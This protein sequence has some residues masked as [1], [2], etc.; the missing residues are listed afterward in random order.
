MYYY[1]KY[2]TPFACSVVRQIQSHWIIFTQLN[3]VAVRSCYWGKFLK[4]PTVISVVFFI[5]YDYVWFATLFRVFAMLMRYPA[6]QVVQY[7]VRYQRLGLI[8]PK[9]N[10]FSVIKR[11]ELKCCISF[12]KLCDLQRRY[13]SGTI[14]VTRWFIASRCFIFRN[15]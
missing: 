13:Q 7:N 3:R 11:E 6:Q 9:N 12:T 1:V 5:R 10:S 4:K 8:P 2:L 14:N 15:I